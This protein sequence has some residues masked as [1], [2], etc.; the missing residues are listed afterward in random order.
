MSPQSTKEAAPR[1]KDG[2]YFQKFNAGDRSRK[3]FPRR[4]ELG[5]MHPCHARGDTGLN[6]NATPE[7]K[8]ENPQ[9]SFRAVTAAQENMRAAPGIII[10]QHQKTR[11]LNHQCRAALGR[12]PMFA[13][14][15]C[16]K[17]QCSTRA[18]GRKHL[19][20]N[21]T[22]E[23]PMQNSLLVACNKGVTISPHSGPKTGHLKLTTKNKEKRKTRN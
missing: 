8:H 20:Q 9:Q 11:K 18:T 4:K 19:H 15:L 6:S 7:R 1:H 5:I 10:L 12:Q 2:N 3:A 17:A 21:S 22:Q 13:K 16:K 23:S 14:E